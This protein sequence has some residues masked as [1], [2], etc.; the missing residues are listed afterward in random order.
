M[1]GKIK[2]DFYSSSELVDH[3]LEIL[4]KRIEKKIN[5]KVNVRIIEL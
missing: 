1:D 5:N 2:S 3:W 4:L